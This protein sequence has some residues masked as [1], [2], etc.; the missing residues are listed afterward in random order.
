[1]NENQ[2]RVPPERRNVTLDP[3]QRQ[4]LVHHGCHVS[5]MCHISRAPSVLLN[6]VVIVV[7][8]SDPFETYARKATLDEDAGVFDPSFSGVY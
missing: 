8:K 3:P 4:L 1:M 5:N 6:R 7:E 2:V